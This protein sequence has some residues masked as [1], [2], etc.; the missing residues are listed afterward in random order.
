MIQ[1]RLLCSCRVDESAHGG[2]SIGGNA[3]ALRVFLDECLVWSE[4]DAV[5]FITRYVAME[6]SLI[7]I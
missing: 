2:D 7:H 4:I 6:L 1:P 3:Y 5:Y